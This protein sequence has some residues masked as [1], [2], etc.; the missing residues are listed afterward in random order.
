[1]QGLKLTLVALSLMTSMNYVHAVD[2]QEVI[3]QI[4]QKKDALLNATSRFGITDRRVGKARN[5][6]EKGPTDAD[7]TRNSNVIAEMRD[8]MDDIEEEVTS[9][10]KWT[11]ALKAKK[12]EL[13]EALIH[14]RDSIT[15][16][17]NGDQQRS[18]MNQARAVTEQFNRM[19]P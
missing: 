1:M 8:L 2:E 4:Q 7:N 17:D 13:K 18:L 6:I 15:R 9:I 10:N 5:I 19:V 12:R 14:V 16:G 11:T 3:K